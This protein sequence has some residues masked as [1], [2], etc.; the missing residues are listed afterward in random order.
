[1]L[2]RTNRSTCIKA[3]SSGS[4]P[5]IAEEKKRRLWALLSANCRGNRVKL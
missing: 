5:D 3:R 2:S 4:G 1:M